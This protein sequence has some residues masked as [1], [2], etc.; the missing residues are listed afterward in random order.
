V[1]AAGF[2]VVAATVGDWDIAAQSAAQLG[3]NLIGIVVA[4][5]LV[6]WVYQRA[7]AR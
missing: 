1:P 5:V 6:L 4:A 2:A 3:V 7:H